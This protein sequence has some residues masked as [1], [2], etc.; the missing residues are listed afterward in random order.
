MIDIVGAA[1][2]AAFA[3]GLFICKGLGVSLAGAGAVLMLLATLG[4][5]RD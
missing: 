1:G 3:G 4:A 2:F 5:M